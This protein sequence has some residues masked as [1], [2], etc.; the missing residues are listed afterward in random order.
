MGV[1]SWELGVGSWALGVAVPPYGRWELRDT[2]SF[3][4]PFPLSPFPFPLS[5]LLTINRFSSEFRLR[6][7]RLRLLVN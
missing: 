4:F 1:G 5:P 7:I 2:L 6:R 3:L